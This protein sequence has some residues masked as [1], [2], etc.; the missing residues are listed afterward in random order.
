MMILFVYQKNLCTDFKLVEHDTAT[1]KSRVISDLH[2]DMH[3]LSSCE[4]KA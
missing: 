1:Y 2:L 3:N 4:M